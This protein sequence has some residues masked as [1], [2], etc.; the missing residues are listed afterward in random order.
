MVDIQLCNRGLNDG[1]RIAYIDTA[2]AFAIILMVVGHTSVPKVLSDWIWSFHMPFF[3]FVSGMTTNWQKRKM[4]EFI[5]ARVQVL[6]IPF[7]CYSF[8]N[9]AAVILINNNS[10][11]G[12]VIG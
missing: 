4:T 3:F 2:K 5:R 10:Q 9:Y 8:V 12:G 7:V 1:K 11:I 6:L